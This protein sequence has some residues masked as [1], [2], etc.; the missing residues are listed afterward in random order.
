MGRRKNLDNFIGEMRARQRNIVFPDTVRNGRAADVF[1]WRGSA[2]PAIVQRIAAWMFGLVY[3]GLGLEFLYL[4]VKMRVEGG[5]SI[6][7]V[8]VM[9]MSVSFV[10]LGIKVFRNGF[11]RRTKPPEE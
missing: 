11:L 8:I 10:L 2:H 9:F 7:I 3:A 5:F 1:L 6:G 4:A